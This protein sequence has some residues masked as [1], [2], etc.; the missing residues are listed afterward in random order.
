MIG[1]TYGDDAVGGDR[2]VGHRGWQGC[3]NCGQHG[4]G[5]DKILPW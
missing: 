4:G 3:R 1:D 5:H 2:G